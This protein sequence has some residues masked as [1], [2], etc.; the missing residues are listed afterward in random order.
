MSDSVSNQ[1]YTQLAHACAFCGEPVDAG[2]ATAV[3]IAVR[4]ESTRVMSFHAH[5]ACLG[6]AMHP[7]SRSVLLDAPNQWGAAG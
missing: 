7:R 3:T 5:V 6:K 2:A 1:P 4:T